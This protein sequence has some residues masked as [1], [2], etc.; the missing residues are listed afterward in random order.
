MNFETKRKLQDMKMYALLDELLRQEELPAML[1]LPTDDRIS[2]AVDAEYQS[3]QE[4]RD[5]RLL[6]ASAIKDST[7]RLKN[8]YFGKD[9]NLSKTE[10]AEYSSLV[11][12]QKGLNMIITG[13]TGIGKTYL[14]S[15][16]GNEACL[17]G[18][19][20]KYYRAPRLLTN[21]AAGRLN[22]TYEK[23]LKALVKPDLLILDDFGLH[24]FDAGLTLDFLEV[25]E[26]RYSEKKAIAIGAQ[27]PV[28][29]W[30][31]I[32]EERTV[33][34]GIMDRMVHK[35]IRIDLK[36]PS[37]RRHSEDKNSPDNGADE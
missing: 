2:M 34:D 28:K 36:G 14:L 19:N 5:K 18:M 26:E 33:A 30:P 10:I 37:M 32:F 22:G 21:M 17:K 16:F 24:K 20:V 8:V 13:P 27:L 12:I 25:I 9:R 31:D 6:K 11:W 35:S 4:R 29:L 1:D 3:R 7:A 23:A 15:A